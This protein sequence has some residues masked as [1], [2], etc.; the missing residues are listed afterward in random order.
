MTNV[1]KRY[2]ELRDAALDGRAT[3]AEIQELESIAMASP[4]RIRDFAEA[5]GLHGDLC[6]L[7]I[8]ARDQRPAEKLETRE[9]SKLGLWQLIPWAIGLAA[10][11]LLIVTFWNRNPSESPSTETFAVLEQTVECLWQ[12]STMPLAEGQRLGTG[13][14][15]LASGFASLRFD[16]QTQLNLEGPAELQILDP[17]HCRLVSGTA[18]ITVRD[19]LRGFVV[20]TPNGRLIDQ[21]TSFGVSVKS[22]GASVVEVFD[23]RVDIEV[24]AT[25]ETRSMTEQTSAWLL[26]EQIVAASEYRV[27][28]EQNS[29]HL[30]QIIAAQG[31]GGDIWVQRNPNIRKGPEDLL[32]VKKSSEQIGFDRQIRLRFDLRNLSDQPIQRTSLQL[33]AV[34]SG[35]GFASR[36]PDAT[37][38]IYGRSI[39]PGTPRLSLE[40]TQWLDLQTETADWLLLDRFVIPKGIQSGA[41]NIESTRLDELLNQH[42]DGVIEL[43]IIRDTPETMGGG[44]VHAFASSRHESIP[45]P[46]LRVW[47]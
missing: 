14:L 23:G 18:V 2:L 28:L 17:M 16:N 35:I 10:S 21:G 37:F 29:G 22:V 7:G 25:G 42:R 15:R 34:P 43:V 44:L 45:G 27:P 46:T 12:T 33:T 39:P 13:R 40:T 6:L 20:D 19:G 1:E 11:I 3:Q 38:S 36:T 31:N 30:T 26:P 24:A 32:L 41:H 47:Q 8:E 9:K 4:E 5:A